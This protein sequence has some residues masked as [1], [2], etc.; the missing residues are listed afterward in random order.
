MPGLASKGADGGAATPYDSGSPLM[1]SGYMGTPDYEASFSPIIAAGAATP[2]GLGTD[3]G[4]TV[5]GGGFGGATSPYSMRSP[6]GGYSPSSPFSTSPMSPGYS[7]QSPG[8]SPTSPMMG[9]TSPSYAVSPRFSPVSP[10][11]TPTSPAYSPTSPSFVSPTS[12][13][14]SPTSPNYS[15]TSPNMHASPTSPSYSPTS[16]SYSPTSPNYSPTSPNFTGS[17]TSPGS[18]LSPTVCNLPLNPNSI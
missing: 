5:G 16:P 15:P 4:T 1:E 17:K 9:A 14:Y 7:P 6:G 8:Y 13:S 18:G 2:H 12:P 11:F 10:A 3:Y